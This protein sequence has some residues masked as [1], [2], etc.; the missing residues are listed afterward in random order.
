MSNEVNR[1][2]FMRRYLKIIDM[3]GNLIP[4]SVNYAQRLFHNSIGRQ[5]LAGLPVRAI[6]LKARREGISTYCQGRFFAEINLKDNRFATV[7]SADAQATDKVFGMS[8]LFQQHMPP[9]FK[10]ETVYSSR[11]MI[12]YSEPHRSQLLCQ[13]AGTMVLGRGGLTHYLHNS[14]VAFWPNAKE[15]FGGAAQEV[16]DLP[17]TMIIMESTANGVG[18]LF[19]DMFWDAVERRKRYP[20]EALSGWIPIFLPWWI[21]PDYQKP[22]EVHFTRT[23]EEQEM[24]DQYRLCDEQLAWRRWAITVRCMGDE[25]L[26]KQ[27]FPANAR[28]AFQTTG[29]NVFP[30]SLLDRMELAVTDP[31]GC[32]VFTYQ[33]GQAFPKDV[34][35]QKDCWI[36]WEYPEP[37]HEYVLGIDAMEGQLSDRDNPRSDRDWHGAVIYDRTTNRVSGLF[38]GQCD[39]DEF[40]RQCV[41]C[42][43]YY[44]ALAAPEING[45]GMVILSAFKRAHYPKIYQR[46]SG[47]DQTAERD[48]DFLGWRT[49][50]M[51]RSLLVSDFKK[52]VK[53][54]APGI[55]SGDILKEMRTFVIDKN[56][57]PIHLP[58]EHDDLLFA[59]MI[60]VQVSMQLP[61]PR[62]QPGEIL[63]RSRMANTERELS[64]AGVLDAWEPGDSDDDEYTWMK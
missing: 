6:V 45:P 21:F 60:A 49:T 48:T 30:L 51:S 52:L 22:V 26:F 38:H 42:A 31:E 14:E 44:D 40:G 59:L 62:R 63:G 50:T 53:E 25:S 5:E 10:R 58:G 61:S 39:P 8:K 17:D 41:W 56:G 16:P 54:D 64:M 33:G 47:T 15:Q 36:L 19:Y 55:P 4:L 35:R 57:K 13:T 7:V 24:V 23:A 12:K 18:G 32:F 2:T 37:G 46:E 29:R 27:E 9:E 34:L 28:E 3:A 43:E 20:D 11:Q 1:L